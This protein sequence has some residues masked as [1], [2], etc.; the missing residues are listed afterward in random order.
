MTSE[1][2][3]RM[4]ESKDATR[5]MQMMKEHYAQ[6]GLSDMDDLRDMPSGA[7]CLSRAEAFR[8][9]R[10]VLTTRWFPRGQGQPTDPGF[11]LQET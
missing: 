9:L 4:G 10:R 8:Y 2:A 1:F 11:A 7:S 6:D 3:T 5:G